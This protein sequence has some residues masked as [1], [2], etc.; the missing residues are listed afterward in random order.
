M[1]ICRSC[2]LVQKYQDENWE[3]ECRSIY[4]DYAPYIVADGAEQRVFTMDA[5]AMSLARSQ[6]IVNYLGENVSLE[7]EGFLIDIGCGNGNFLSVFARFRPHWQLHG[8]EL[9]DRHLS[10]LK[11]IPSFRHLHV[12]DIMS[13][14]RRFDVATMIHSLEHIPNP[15]RFLSGIREKI[16]SD[17]GLLLVEVPDYPT[18]PFDL[19]I[20]DHLSHFSTATLGRALASSGFECLALTNK[21]VAKENTAIATPGRMAVP[22]VDVDEA[23]KVVSTA[24][25]WLRRV[26][27]EADQ[28][29]A[30]G[31][32]GVFGTAI[33]AN[34]LAGGLG[35]SVAFY[36]DEDSARIGKTW[37]GRQVISPAQ[38][39]EDARVLVPLAPAIAMTVATRLNAGPGRY[40][41]LGA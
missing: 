17:D 35:D 30:S 10:T 40:H 2:G 23:S 8:F 5:A 21:S 31:P 28:L 16:I 3:E 38:V 1:A 34:W 9:D 24:L 7:N 4:R 12:G 29:A 37:L 25:S 32:V 14:G 11:Y 33:G 15:G 18:N 13:V 27:D 22:H 19:L 41:P 20:A 26:A 36:V 39:P 6:I